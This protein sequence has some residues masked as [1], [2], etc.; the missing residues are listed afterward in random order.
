MLFRHFPKQRLEMDAGYRY[1]PRLET[2]YFV[3]G[4]EANSRSVY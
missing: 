4:I 2:I 3:A 1:Q